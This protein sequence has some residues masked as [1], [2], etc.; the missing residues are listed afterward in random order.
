VF[1]QNRTG[2]AG[3]Q[4]SN[5]LLSGNKTTMLAGK[6]TISGPARAALFAALAA[7]VDVPEP[8]GLW[9]FAAAIL[10]ILLKRWAW[11]RLSL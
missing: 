1:V 2:N 3:L 9:I 4:L 5:N 11:K 7:P 8:S 6:G 10:G